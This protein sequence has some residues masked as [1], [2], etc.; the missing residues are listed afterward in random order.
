M[1]SRGHWKV[2]E[3]HQAKEDGLYPLQ[4]TAG[5]EHGEKV[6]RGQ[7]RADMHAR[8]FR[9]P[10]DSC[11]LHAWEILMTTTLKSEQGWVAMGLCRAPRP[12]FSHRLDAMRKS[13]PRGLPG[14]RT[15]QRC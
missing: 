4:L 15:E 1:A 14:E 11:L 6:L 5:R 10:D 12:W 7:L 8:Q 2:L 13:W 3:H 9:G